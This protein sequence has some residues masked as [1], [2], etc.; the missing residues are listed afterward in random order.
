[1]LASFPLL[2]S[3]RFRVSG[4]ASAHDSILSVRGKRA[5]GGLVGQR[6]RD[7]CFRPAFCTF[8]WW[9]ASNGPGDGQDRALRLQRALLDGMTDLAWIKDPDSR[10]L[11][12]NRALAEMA[13]TT[14]EEMVGRTDHDFF[15]SEIA[16][17]YLADDRKVL[18]TGE[19]SRTRRAHRRRFGR[20][21]LAADHQEGGLRRKRSALRHLGRR[22][23]RHRVPR[24]G[25]R[26]AA[27]EPGVGATALAHQRVDRKRAGTGVGRL[28]R[29]NGPVHQ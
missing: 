10:F 7:L 25:T 5:G 19:I 23:R 13:G 20:R 16:D 27:S 29:R 11:A 26:A 6:R 9:V 3:K 28:V 22:A 14:P 12:V 24:C 17:I 1:M 15:P 18:R 8:R 4:C 2:T 21:A